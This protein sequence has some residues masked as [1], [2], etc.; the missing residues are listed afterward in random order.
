MALRVFFNSARNPFIRN[1][2]FNQALKSSPSFFSTRQTLNVCYIANKRFS[3]IK[4]FIVL[5]EG[6]SE[7]DKRRLIENIERLAD[8]QKYPLEEFLKKCSVIERYNGNHKNA[9]ADW[10]GQK[11]RELYFDISCNNLGK[12]LKSPLIM[13]RC[14]GN[15]EKAKEEWKNIRELH[16][17]MGIGK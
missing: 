2:F 9:E 17:A 13:E 5:E 15:L 16:E 4:E 1:G 11:L 3:S 12:F 7:E 6:S 8:I 14:N 10:K